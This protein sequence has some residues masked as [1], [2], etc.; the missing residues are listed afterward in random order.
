M[1]YRCKAILFG[2]CLLFLTAQS[3]CIPTKRLTVAA[4]GTLLQEV[5]KSSSK[6]SD[7]TII[8]EGAPAYLMLIDGLI[9]EGTSPQAPRS[10][11]NV[12]RAL[13]QE[14]RAR[15]LLDRGLLGKLDQPEHPFRGGHGRC[16]Q[17]GNPDGEGPGVG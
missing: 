4:V 15:P 6:Q 16:S 17:G 2:L 8:R 7:I 12:F 3:G 14:G 10:I 1:D 11:Q 9:E 5:A 13:R